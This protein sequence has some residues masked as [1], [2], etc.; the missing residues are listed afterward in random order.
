[1]L[2]CEGKKILCTVGGNISWY[3]QYQ[4]IDNVIV[5]CDFVIHKVNVD[6]S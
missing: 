6:E 3:S 1:M 5:N 4:F 2:R